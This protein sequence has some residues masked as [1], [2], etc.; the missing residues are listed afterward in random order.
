[1]RDRQWI[2][3]SWGESDSIV[4][5]IGKVFWPSSLSGAAQLDYCFQVKG[6]RKEISE[7]DGL[8]LVV[9]T[10]ECAQVAGQRGGVAG[11]VGHGGRGDLSEQR[12]GFRAEARYAA[13][14][15]R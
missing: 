15:R 5:E 6:L 12:A 2:A 9:G 11:D 8:N 10:G 7:G 14:L 4:P 13:G 3:R 1:M